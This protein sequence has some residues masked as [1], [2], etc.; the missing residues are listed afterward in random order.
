MEHNW[1][2][3][4]T[5]II[6]ARN[7]FGHIASVVSHALSVP[8]ISEVVVIEGGSTDDTWMKIKEIEKEMSPV[9]RCYQQT[10]IG[11]FNA[12]LEG[13]AQA[14]FKYSIIWDADGTVPLECTKRILLHAL[15]TGN[16]TM[17]DRLR[18]TIEQS[19]MQPANFFGNWVFAVLWSPIIR[20]KPRDMLCGTKVF[21]TT[22]F[23]SIPRE[24]QASDPYGD[25][26]LVATARLLN[27]QID[28][29]VVD[30]KARTYGETNIHRWSGGI[31]LLKTTLLVYRMLIKKRIIDANSR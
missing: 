31:S 11:K 4:V 14:K 24:L 2:P 26:A 27:K 13:A 25:F 22:V 29:V 30:Y 12:V 23:T 18:G 19:A 21:E 17:G 9:V 20:S 5:C 28:S 3:G 6:P 7:E 8:E 1:L 10:G 15:L 16:S